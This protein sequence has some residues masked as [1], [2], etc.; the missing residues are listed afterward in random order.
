[1][2]E[3]SFLAVQGKIDEKWISGVKK[4]RERVLSKKGGLGTQ[5]KR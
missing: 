3:E 1:M 5:E 4:E 2:R